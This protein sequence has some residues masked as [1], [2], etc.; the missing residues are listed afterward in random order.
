MELNDRGMIETVC[1][2]VAI[3][4]HATLVRDRG[5]PVVGCYH[6]FGV[7]VT[8][9]GTSPSARA[10]HHRE[11]S[12]GFLGQLREHGVPGMITDGTPLVF[13]TLYVACR[14]LRASRW[15][16]TEHTCSVI[17]KVQRRPAS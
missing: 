11:R 14:C 15:Q 17:D 1:R 3:D 4:A 10:R 13:G 5:R 8:Q 9:N 6:H 7:G 16:L 2:M 12:A